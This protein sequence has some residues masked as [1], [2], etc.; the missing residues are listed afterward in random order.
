MWS[1]L[2]WLFG[3]GAPREGGTPASATS[4]ALGILVQD[5]TAGR[6]QDGPATSAA[7]HE[8][9]TLVQIVTGPAAVGEPRPGG[10]TA[11]DSSRVWNVRYADPD[12]HRTLPDTANLKD[13]LA[14]GEL[15]REV[16]FEVHLRGGAVVRGH[17]TPSSVAWECPCGERL[18][19]L[20]DAAHPVTG[21]LLVECPCGRWYWCGPGP[22]QV[23]IRGVWQ[24]GA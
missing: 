13:L 11:P 8:L 16:A 21:G 7:P 1:R 24:A 15:L 2:A 19:L 6:R 14:R 3:P 5:V 4:R 12:R 18:D 17:A 10:P 9:G 20:S 23:G 22:S